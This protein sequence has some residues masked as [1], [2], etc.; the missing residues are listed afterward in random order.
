[1]QKYSFVLFATILCS[2][3]VL[4]ANERVRGEAT[5]AVIQKVK[6]HI[7]VTLDDKR[8]ALIVE[9]LTGMEGQ[10]FIYL[11]LS[12]N[13]TDRPEGGQPFT[14]HLNGKQQ[15]R[16]SCPIGPLPM[17]EGVSYELGPLAA[18]NHL[19]MS[20]FTGGRTVFPYNDVACE[21]TDSGSLNQ[22]H[23]RG[24]FHV[25]SNSIPTAVSLQLRPINPPFDMARRL[26]ARE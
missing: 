16:K 15:A 22:F 19:V 3:F 6:L 1:M 13:F 7:P 14:V 24:F 21:Y 2:A 17:G 20:I 4:G 8:R 9:K 11:D 5:P 25:L 10:G 23:I 12:I 18:Y 26:L